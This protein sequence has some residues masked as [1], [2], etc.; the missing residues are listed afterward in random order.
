MVVVLECDDPLDAL[1]RNF[2]RCQVRWNLP[3]GRDDQVS[4]FLAASISMKARAACRTT[5]T[6]RPQRRS[7]RRKAW[8]TALTEGQGGAL[9]GRQ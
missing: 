1:N 7:G 9:G 4:G 3:A 5:T 8:S 2:S 6:R